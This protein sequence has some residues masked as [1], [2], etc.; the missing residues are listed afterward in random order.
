MECIS[1]DFQLQFVTE[2]LWDK[3]FISVTSQRLIVSYS[4]MQSVSIFWLTFTTTSFISLSQVTL[5]AGAVQPDFP[6]KIWD[7]GYNQDNKGI[8]QRRT[9][10]NKL[11]NI[12][13]NFHI[14]KSWSHT[15]KVI[16]YKS[17]K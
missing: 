17:Y 9:E 8:K 3:A 12:Q 16:I 15:C 4:S 7:L 6:P 1:F 13:E 10:R 11:K 5:I 14:A 2:I